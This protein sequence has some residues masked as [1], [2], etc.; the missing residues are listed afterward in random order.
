M[1][2]TAPSAPAP[3]AAPKQSSTS[4]TVPSP[5]PAPV[6]PAGA[7]SVPPTAHE[8]ESDAYMADIAVDMADLAREPEPTPEKATPKKDPATGKFLKKTESEGNPKEAGEVEPEP[9]LEPEP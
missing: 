3:V 4:Q 7:G 9:A 6:P 2:V 5:K 1:P 8:P